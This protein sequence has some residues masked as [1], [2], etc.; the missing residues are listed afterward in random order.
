M[1]MI[2]HLFFLSP[3]LVQIIVID[4]NMP[5]QFT[6]NEHKNYKQKNKKIK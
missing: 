2:F 5:I 1:I 3:V 4:Y 6:H